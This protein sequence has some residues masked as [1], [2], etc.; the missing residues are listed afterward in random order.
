VDRRKKLVNT[1]ES[2]TKRILEIAAGRNNASVYAKIRIADVLN[3]ERSGIS[4]DLYSYGLKGHFDFVVADEAALPLFAVEYD[5]PTHLDSATI[6]RD[7][8]KN[9]LCERL[10][11]PLARVRDEHIF[12]QARGMDYLTWL[13]EVYFTFQWLLRA[14]EEGSFPADEPPDPMMC[15]SSPHLS[16]RFPL[17]VSVH[18]RNS[19]RDLYSNKL[20]KEDTPLA[21]SGDDQT[22][23]TNALLLLPLADGSI[24][25]SQST[26]YLRWFGIAPSE[27]AEEIAIVNLETLVKEHVESRRPGLSVR[28]ARRALIE[29]LRNHKGICL[30]G[31]MGNSSGF[32][33]GY[34][35]GPDGKWWRVGALGNEP[36]VKID[37][38]RK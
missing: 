2:A 22:G 34:H 8:M 16:G 10:G 32:S 15:F 24:V 31:P 33:I 20:I 36:E 26:I 13:S 27:V 7:R 19:L 12:R 14:Q 30:G 25:T 5:G 3:M 1:H 9:E 6:D 11:L 18:A 35:Q 17:F 4:N 37:I 23:R 28:E 21:F 29:F 38:P